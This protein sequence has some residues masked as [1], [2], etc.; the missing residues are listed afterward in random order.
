M[1]KLHL[2]PPFFFHKT[3]CALSI[4]LHQ[5]GHVPYEFLEF[6]LRHATPEQLQ[7]IE[8][9]NPVSFCT[10]KVKLHVV[11]NNNKKNRK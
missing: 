11:T 10:V 9:C 1:V 7:R 4:A 5:V 6:S 8:M 2:F 3:D